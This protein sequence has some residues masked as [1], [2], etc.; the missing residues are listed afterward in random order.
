MKE[1]TRQ[2]SMV[3]VFLAA[4]ALL[5]AMSGCGGPTTIRTS[6]GRKYDLQESRFETLWVEPQIV[7]SD[8]LMTLIRSER[9][10]SIE[11]DPLDRAGR[12]KK[13]IEFRIAEMSCQVSV[14]LY[15]SDLR[16]I[17]PLMVRDLPTGFYR[18]TVNMEKFREPPPRYE[19]F[20][21]KADYCGRT[22]VSLV[23]PD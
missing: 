16:M 1:Q 3:F 4:A 7:A 13:S 12:P 8:S 14:G 19:T 20:F 22:E 11:I 5:A 10:D 21:L 6:D 2:R 23:A 17:Y 9:I 15:N 18:L